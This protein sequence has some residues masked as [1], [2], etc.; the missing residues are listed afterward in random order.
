MPASVPLTRQ[1]AKSRNFPPL[2]GAFVNAALTKQRD[3]SRQ[4]Y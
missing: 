3:K 1:P 4:S 2:R